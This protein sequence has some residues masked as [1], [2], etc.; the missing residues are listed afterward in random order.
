MMVV[1]LFG[2]ADCHLCVEVEAMLA[3]LRDPYPHR[4]EK[5]DIEGDRALFQQ[6]RYTIPVV[7]IGGRELLAP[8]EVDELRAALRAASL[9]NS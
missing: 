8:I 3:T 1:T 5:V 2:K 4:L 7:R 9:S 6:Y